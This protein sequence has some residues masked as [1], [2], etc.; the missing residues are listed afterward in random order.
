[1]RRLSEE[2]CLA[3]LWQGYLEA[4]EGQQRRSSTAQLMGGGLADALFFCL[5]V[6]H[7][8]LPTREIVSFPFTT[9]SVTLHAYHSAACAGVTGDL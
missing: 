2:H 8:R 7:S 9:S 1:M 6:L 4:S 5:S 3:P